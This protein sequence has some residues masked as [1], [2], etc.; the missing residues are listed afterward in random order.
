MAR[1]VRSTKLLLR[2]LELIAGTGAALIGLFLFA[3]VLSVTL[4]LGERLE[5]TSDLRVFLM[6]VP[7][8]VIVV[9]AYIQSVRNRYW[10]FLIVFVGVLGNFVFIVFNAG[11]N[12]YAVAAQ[13]SWT[14]FAISTDLFLTTFLLGVAVINAIVSLGFIDG[15]GNEGLSV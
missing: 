9:G 12:Y 13:D 5:P 4:S 15:V 10:G 8:I 14:Q 7:G 6:L 1:L 2:A 3:R 11:L